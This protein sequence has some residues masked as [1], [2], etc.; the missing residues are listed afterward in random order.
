MSPTFIKIICLLAIFQPCF[1]Q[2]QAI[3]IKEMV[4]Q[5]KD[6]LH[7]FFRTGDNR[8]LTFNYASPHGN[9]SYKRNYNKTFLVGYDAK[10][11]QVFNT[12]VRELAGNKYQGGLEYNGGLHIFYADGKKIYRYE[13]DGNTG[14]AKGAPVQVMTVKQDPEHFYKG[15]SADSGFCY[16]LFDYDT[17]RGATST[18]EGVVLDKNLNV[19]TTFAFAMRKL[20]NY[21]ENKTCVLSQEGLFYMVHAVR[22]KSKKEFRPLQYL[23]TEISK[24]GKEATSLLEDLPEG[25]FN[26]VIWKPTKNGLS[27]TGLLAKNEKEGFKY[28]LTGNFNSWQK[29]L[30]DIKEQDFTTSPWWQSATDKFLKEVQAG[31]LTPGINIVNS[32]IN[33]DGSMTMVMQF[34]EIKYTFS[35]NYSYTDSHKGSLYGMKIRSDGSLDWL[36]VVPC[37]QSESTY[38]IYSGAIV[39]QR[40]NKDVVIVFHD[41]EKNYKRKPEENFFGMGLSGSWSDACQLTAIVIKDDGTMMRTAVGKNMDP[42]HH[43]APNKPFIAYDNEILYTSYHD[44]NLGRST[45]KFGVIRLL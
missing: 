16:I 21:I 38:P 35:G 42:D 12:P 15:Y 6:Y 24:D 41:N 17:E 33:D 4:D 34:T 37:S 25:R 44:R 32:F 36:Q 28:I 39:L 29:R 13:V 27:F 22:V 23:L 43:M 26:N 1:A 7:E 9:A 31:G 20:D 8:Y 5:E 10:L 11:N 30:S 40:K 2:K 45:Y 19:V 3:T 14:N 18:Y